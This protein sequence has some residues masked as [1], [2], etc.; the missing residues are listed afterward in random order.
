MKPDENI[1][2]RLQELDGSDF[3]ISD[4]QPD[5]TGWEIYDSLGDYIGDVDDLVF[6]NESL[7]VRYIITKLEGYEL[8]EE[9]RVLIPIGLVT[10]KEDKD[11]VLLTEAISSKLPFLPD[12]ESGKITPLEEL[13]IRD[14]LT[15]TAEHVVE[16]MNYKHNPAD[17]FYNH[18]HFDDT[19]YQRNPPGKDGLPPGEI[20]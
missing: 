5:I 13:Q 3:E 9:K 14:V 16:V 12:Y 18:T 11:E 7:K 2:K 17:D 10:L 20:I 8:E 19:G 15:G 6:D 1:N 4:Q